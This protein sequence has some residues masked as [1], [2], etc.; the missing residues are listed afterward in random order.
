MKNCFECGSDYGVE[1]HHIIPRSLG[2]TKT[3][4]LCG[5]CHMKAHGIKSKRRDNLSVMIKKGLESA[6]ANGV[7]LGRPKGKT[8]NAIILKK[9]KNQDII[10]YLLQ[11]VSIRKTAKNCNTSIS[12]V[13]RIKKLII[14]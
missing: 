13:Q 14:T 2:G 10:N 8:E 5:L 6:K 9:N 7:V 4:P 12:Q 11:G 3:I 1:E